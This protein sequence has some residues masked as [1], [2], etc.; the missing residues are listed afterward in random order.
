MSN[1]GMT[2][3][4]FDLGGKSLQMVEVQLRLKS[5]L[6]TDIS[7]IE[8]FQAP[9][10][11]SL[12]NQLNKKGVCSGE[13]SPRNDRAQVRQQSL[14]RQLQRRQRSRQSPSVPTRAD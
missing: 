4:F 11:R 10:I 2:A 6:E 12:A 13:T 14:G 5:L 9:T 1:V 8:L 7:V 3:N